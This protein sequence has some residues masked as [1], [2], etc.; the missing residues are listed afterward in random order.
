MKTV[1]AGLKTANLATA[2]FNA[3]LA[4]EAPGKPAIAAQ[5]ISAAAKQFPTAASLFKATGAPAKDPSVELAV[6]G[7]NQCDG[8]DSNACGT[9]SQ[10]SILSYWGNGTPAYTHQQADAKIRT[11]DMFSA[12]DDLVRY[13]RSR[14]FRAA[15]KTDAGLGDI[16]AMLDQGVPVQVLIDPGSKSDFNQHYIAVTGYKTDASGK[17]AGLN[18]TDPA[19]GSKYTMPVEEFMDKWSNLKMG[20]VYTGM[21]R[22]MMTYVPQGNFPITGPDGKARKASDINLPSNGLLDF[23]SD[24]QPGRVMGNAIVNIV[25]G[26]NQDKPAKILG[27]VVQGVGAIAGNLNAIPGN[28]IHKGGNAIADWGSSQIAKP[29]IFNKVAGGAAGLYGKG[30]SVIGKGIQKV[31]NFVAWGIGKI[32]QAS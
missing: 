28:Y 17:I 21:S 29:G 1:S 7:M 8:S 20:G 27:G 16:K 12:P 23:I 22:V 31:G 13:A 4:K 30:V 11:G 25:N 6:K 2:K 26:W 19:G 5:S 24:S 14:G 3:T 15:M 10:A 9:T 18:I 32:G